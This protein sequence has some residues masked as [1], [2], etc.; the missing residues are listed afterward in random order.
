M[1]VKINNKQY[2]ATITKTADYH[3]RLKTGEDYRCVLKDANETTGVME[4]YFDKMELTAIL[5]RF[6]VNDLDSAEAL[7]MVLRAFCYNNQSMIIESDSLTNQNGYVFYKNFLDN[8]NSS[9][10]QVEIDKSYQDGYY[11]TLF[12]DDDSFNNIE[13]Y[14]VEDDEQLCK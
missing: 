14:K 1:K 7:F 9:N 3:D 11:V 8:L 2:F 5:E 4:F 13:N 10:E 12:D 6:I